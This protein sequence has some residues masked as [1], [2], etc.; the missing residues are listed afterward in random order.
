MKTFH[1]IVDV[2]SESKLAE[3]NKLAGPFKQTNT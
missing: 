1:A 2:L 3:L